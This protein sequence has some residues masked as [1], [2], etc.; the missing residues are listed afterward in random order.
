HELKTPLTS[1]RMSLHLLLDG[2][3]G[4]PT[5][6]QADL[7]DTAREES[8]RLYRIIEDLLDLSRIESGRA[9]LNLEPT[10]PADLIAAA[11]DPLRPAFHDAGLRPAFSPPTDLPDVLTSASRAVH[12]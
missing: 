10:A 5:P 3:A 6:A 9:R 2:T 4:V 12:A 1:L 11:V 7:L 8:D